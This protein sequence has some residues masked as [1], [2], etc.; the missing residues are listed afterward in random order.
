MMSDLPRSPECNYF[1]LY[2]PETSA[3]VELVANRSYYIEA[4]YLSYY[5]QG[6]FKI[7][8]EVPNNNSRLPFQAYQVEEITI[9]AEHQP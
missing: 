6:N 5:Y 7:M 8:V 4:Y 3:T 1:Y 9:S 2:K